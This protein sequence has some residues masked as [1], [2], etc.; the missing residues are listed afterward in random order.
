MTGLTMD[1]VDREILTA[2]QENPRDCTN[3][4]IGD[5]TGVS[6]ST[7]SKRI[8][9]LEEQGVIDGYHSTIDYE[10]AGYPVRVLLICSTPITERESLVEQAQDIEGVI[11][12]RELMTGRRN[13]HIEVVGTSNEEVMHIA[14]E[15]DELGYTINDESLVRNE[16]HQPCVRFDGGLTSPHG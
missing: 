6:P 5:R 10:L 12:I 15:L 4:A 9:K 8:T 16:Y 11:N 2:L 1:E 13:V 7:V 14:H 3:A